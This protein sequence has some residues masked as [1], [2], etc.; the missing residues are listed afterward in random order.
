MPRKEK[1]NKKSKSPSNKLEDLPETFMKEIILEKKEFEGSCLDEEFSCRDIS[2]EHCEELR[3]RGFTNRKEDLFLEVRS[4]EER[5]KFTINCEK[6]LWAEKLSKARDKNANLY[7]TALMN[8]EKELKHEIKELK[9]EIEKNIHALETQEQMI[10]S[11]IGMV[12]KINKEKIIDDFFE[13]IGL[14]F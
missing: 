10:L 11:Q 14:N 8:K 6:E 12:Y 4:L 9:Q 2:P 13:I 5:Y 7:K 3:K 1:K